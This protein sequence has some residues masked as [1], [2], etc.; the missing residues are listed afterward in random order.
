MITRTTQEFADEVF[1]RFMA[2]PLESER[3]P[4]KVGALEAS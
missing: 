3:R 4:A 1:R 2:L